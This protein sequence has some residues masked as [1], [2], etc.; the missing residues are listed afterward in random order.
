MFAF[1]APGSALSV[2]G[3]AMSH[4][5]CNVI[6]LTDRFVLSEEFSRP[7][8]MVPRVF[9]SRP[10]RFYGSFENLLQIGDQ[11]PNAPGGFIEQQ[12]NHPL[13]F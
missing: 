7:G 13:A 5:K 6:N 9:S 2:A 12:C 1:H 8:F 10:D 3:P 11:A 4:F